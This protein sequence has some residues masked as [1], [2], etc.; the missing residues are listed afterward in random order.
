MPLNMVDAQSPAFFGSKVFPQEAKSTFLPK[1]GGKNVMA[2]HLFGQ[3]NTHMRSS[4]PSYSSSVLEPG[5]TQINH[6]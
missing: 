6:H 3:D 2:D 5:K 1:I 4:H